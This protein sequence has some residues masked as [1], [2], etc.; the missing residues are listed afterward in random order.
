[1]TGHLDCRCSTKKIT[2]SE[3]VC[4]FLS[5]SA[6]AVDGSEIRDL[7]ARDLRILDAINY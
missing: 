4:E 2:T 6:F 1:V 3:Y 7:I 5:C